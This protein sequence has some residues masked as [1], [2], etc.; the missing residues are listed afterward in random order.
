[1]KPVKFKEANTVYA[2]DQSEYLPLPVHK[3]EDGQVTSCWKLSFWERLIVF[4][5]G[6]VWLSNLTFN[7]PLQPIFISVKK[8]DMFAKAK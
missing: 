3:D 8:S 4:F 5:A 2:E 7:Q 6:R 1:M